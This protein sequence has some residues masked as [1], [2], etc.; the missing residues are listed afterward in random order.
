MLVVDLG[1]SRQS[2]YAPLT[3][4]GPD[5]LM[6]LGRFIARTIADVEV[7]THLD[8]AMVT[9]MVFRSECVDDDSEMAEHC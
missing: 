3:V 9:E 8:R 2:N 4:N 1:L 7:H 6:E 5:Y